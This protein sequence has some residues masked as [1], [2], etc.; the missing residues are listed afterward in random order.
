MAEKLE[1]VV[2]QTAFGWVGIL[3]SPRGLLNVTLPQLTM[4]DAQ[5]ALGDIRHQAIWS[6]SLS[7]DLATRVSAYFVGQEATFPDALDFSMATRFQRKVWEATR[8]IPYG[9]TRSY[10]WVAEQV[11]KPRAARAVGQAMGANPLPII[12]PCHR[13]LATG[14]LL[15]GFG[16]GLEMKRRLLSLEG[17]AV[18]A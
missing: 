9:Q 16:G 2:F 3:S 10:G 5:R 4:A 6:P 13:V 15:G 11:G 18:P 12:V 14:G 1:Y 17:A 7:D 8:L